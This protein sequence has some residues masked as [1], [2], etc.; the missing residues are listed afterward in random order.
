[1]PTPLIPQEVYL[2]EHYSSLQYYGLA[3]DAWEAVVKHCD[4]CLDRFMRNLPADYRSRPLPEQ[5]DIVWGER[6]IPN[7]RGTLQ[8]LYDGYIKRSHQ[9][10]TCYKGFQGS[11]N[12]CVRGQRDFSPAWFDEVEQG[13]LDKYYELLYAAGN[14]AANIWPTAG[15]YWSKGELSY[16]FHPDSR[17]PLPDLKQWPKYRLNPAVAIETAAPVPQTG[18]YL[19]LIDDSCAQL[20][21]A[22]QAA[23][24]ANVGYDPESL[25]NVSREPTRWVLVERVPGEFVEDPL[26]D[27]LAG[28]AAL[29]R[30]GRV[31]A[32]QTCPRNGW[33][34]TPAKP[35][36]RRWFNEGE[37][38]PAIEGSDYGAT[39]WLWDEDQAGS[40]R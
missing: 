25:Q 14:L 17:G 11:I 27:L 19:P 1:M 13:A 20:L 2:L 18:I 6:V 31:P 21:I 28:G 36:S 29:T 12:G 4:A 34:H 9:D 35:G 39:F 10:W 23:D 26:A 32:G 30:I 8:F 24:K 40:N 22:G 5:P 37:V 7:F 3:R 16:E 33:W 38:F 15:A